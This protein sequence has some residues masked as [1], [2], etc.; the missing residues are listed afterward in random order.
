MKCGQ[1]YKHVYVHTCVHI[2]GAV[3]PLYYLALIERQS[4]HDVVDARGDFR[5]EVGYIAFSGPPR[6]C[7]TGSDDQA[8]RDS[9][10]PCLRKEH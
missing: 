1:Q 2:P 6:R 5:P 10:P 8:F 3:W 7:D 9:S 4:E